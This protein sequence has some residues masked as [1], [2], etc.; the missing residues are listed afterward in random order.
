MGTLR[1]TGTKWILLAA[2]LGF[3]GTAHAA[4][5]GPQAM[6]ARLRAHPT[7]DNAILLGSWYAGHQQFACAVDTFRAALK[8]DPNS[9]QLHYL[10]GLALVGAGH[11]PEA[12]P[13]IKEST[14]LDPHVIKPHLILASL[15]DQA[16]QRAEGEQQWK[17]ALAIEPHSVPALEGLSADLLA[18]EDNVGVIQLL[19]DVPRNEKLSITL[20]QALGLLNY[21]D[22]AN[23]VLTKALETSPDSVQLASAMTVVLVKQHR[24]QDAINLLQHAVDK[25]PGNP[26]AEVQLFRLLVLTNHINLA[27]PLGPRLLAK[28]P[29]DPEVLYLNGIV[30]RAVGDYATAKTHLEEA[31]AIDGN[32]FNSRY[33]LG[34]VLVFLKEWEEAKEQ[35]QKAID[36]GATESQVHFEMA[37]A[38]RA[39]GETGRAQ[40]EMKQYQQIKKSEESTLE[41]ATSAAQGDSELAAGKVTE[42]IGH[43]REATDGE[44]ANAGYKFKLS[45]ALH[46]SGDMGGERTQ[47]E[48]AVKLDPKLA[49]AQNELGYVLSRSGDADGAVEHFRMAVDAAPGWAEAW[50]NL[51]AE[52]AVS[53][54]F[55]DAREAVAKALALDPRNA[56]AREL[57]AQLAHDPAA[58]QAHP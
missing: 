21:L 58:Q 48:Q 22:E 46:Q 17:L 26:G 47:L 18:R 28:R 44:P 30:E 45:I 11:V 14:R 5:T 53:G 10:T 37:K 25:N 6:T 50:I 15:Y 13:E 27:R 34:M 42:A 29:R 56:Q 12:V 39:L 20:A 16:A 54:H 36:L 51:A 40:E 9:A 8:A 57:S 31:V 43:Y 52:L 23:A 4:C 33:N 41:A 24:Y 3:A 7:T 38:L 32:F 35:L 1:Q 55:A 19:H 2:C 49:G